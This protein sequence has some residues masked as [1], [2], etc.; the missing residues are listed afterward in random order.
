MLQLILG[1]ELLHYRTSITLRGGVAGGSS[2]TDYATPALGWPLVILLADGQEVQL[3][4]W[5]ANQ[6]I[7]G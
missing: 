4:A 1:E 3:G 2:Y 6:E 5:E 7:R